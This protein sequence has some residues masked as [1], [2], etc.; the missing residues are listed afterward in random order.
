MQE[1]ASDQQA[2][3]TMTRCSRESNGSRHG[4]TTSG[5]LQEH[6]GAEAVSLNGDCSAEKKYIMEETERRVAAILTPCLKELVLKLGI[7]SYSVDDS[8]T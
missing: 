1:R 2:M 7:C 8:R 6:Q 5:P 3:R 4:P